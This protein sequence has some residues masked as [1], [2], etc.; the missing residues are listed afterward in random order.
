MKP[1]H[2]MSIYNE[3]D[4]NKKKKTENDFPEIKQ[5]AHNKH[6]DFDIEIVMWLKKKLFFS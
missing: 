6:L 5:L 3:L 1:C 2:V 4:P